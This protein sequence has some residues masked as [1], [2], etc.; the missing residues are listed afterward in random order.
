MLSRI[1]KYKFSKGQYFG[2][3]LFVFVAIFHKMIAHDFGKVTSSDSSIIEK[4]PAVI[5]YSSQTLD[6]K[7][8][9]VGPFDKQNVP[10][11][12]YRHWLGTDPLGRDLFAGLV[13]GTNIAFKVGFIS[14]F[15][16]LLI[17]LFFGFLGGYFGDDKFKVSR[18]SLLIFALSL[19]LSLFY[20]LYTSSNL[21]W[22]FLFLPFVLLLALEFFSKEA[23][24]KKWVI[25]LDLIIQR[26]VEI[27]NAFP[28]MFLIL[29]LLALFLKPGFWNVIFVIAVLRWPTITRHLRA[30]ILK[31]KEQKFVLSARAIGQSHIKIFLKH[32][33]PLT[34]STISILVAFGF[35]SAVLLESSLSFLGI[36]I[37]VDEVTWGSMLSVARTNIKMWWLAVF[38]ALMIYGVISLFNSLG[39]TI[40]DKIQRVRMLTE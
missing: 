33:L 1:R 4:I 8:R 34:V 9:G 15:I 6:S 24:A 23:I 38:P 20:F 17:G 3:T 28:N 12:Y 5:P 27:F 11:L 37:P 39:D 25:P 36:G 29:V 31:L 30:E 10:S 19:F 35:S 32:I 2:L 16:A 18:S 22:F 14:G 26:V 40:S 13:H 7:N 21:K